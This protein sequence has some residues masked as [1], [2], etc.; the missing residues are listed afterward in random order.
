MQRKSVKIAT[1]FCGW[2]LLATTAVAWGD[3]KSLPLQDF[4]P[5]SMLKVKRTEIQ[6]A[7]FPVID[8]HSHFGYRLKGS[9]E[10]LDE[11]VRVMDRNH[12]AMCVSL[13][14]KLGQTLDEHQ[15]YLWSRFPNRFA[16]FVHLDWMGQGE[17]DKP[18]TWACHRPEF[19]RH[20]VRQLAV[21]KREGA[22]GLK[23][24]KRFGL[25][26]RNPDGSLIEIDDAR[27]DPIWKACGD[28]GFPIIMHTADP[29]AFFKPIDA[30]N[31]RWEE[32]SR[33]PDWSFPPDKFPTRESLLEARNR[34]IARH[35]RTQF[36]GAHGAN[37]SED[38]AKVGQWLEMYPN[39]HVEFASRIGELGRQPYTARRF[40]IKFADRVIFGTDGPWPEA[41]LSQYW[42]FFETYD[43]YFPYSEKEFPP[44]GFWNIYGVGLPD[45]VLKKIY[46]ENLLRLLPSIEKKFNQT[47]K[48]SSWL[49]NAIR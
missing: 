37:N 40:L 43:E 47:R 49:Q 38:L 20:V 5:H 19:A 16:I 28:L 48:E 27:W 18:E 42:R 23:L 14:A 25:S 30:N 8:V 11:F 2:A 4:R 26:Y 6:G 39:L 15:K 24:F 46:S 1:L 44:Q 3:E 41:R 17:Q 31:E 10:K 29:A 13:D 45:N 34:V 33:H 32:L 21:A 35:P 9:S 22:C 12:I 7:R 36:I